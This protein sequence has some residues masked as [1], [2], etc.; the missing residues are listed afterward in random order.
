MMPALTRDMPVKSY[1]EALC[2][3]CGGVF[4][5]KVGYER[6]DGV[7]DR[8]YHRKQLEDSE[9]WRQLVE[10]T[11]TPEERKVI[12]LGHM[13]Q[14]WGGSEMTQE[15]KELCERWDKLGQQAKKGEK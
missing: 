14:I 12:A 7:C 4:R 5:Y 15:E 11:F 3:K 2:V 6:S 10:R 1:C 9:R 13:K 8:C